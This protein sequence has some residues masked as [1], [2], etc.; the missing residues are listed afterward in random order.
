[1]VQVLK[2][3]SDAGPP[4]LI[5]IDDASVFE[6]GASSAALEGELEGRTEDALNKLR[7]IGD[8]IAEVCGSIQSAVAARMA[9]TKPDEFVLEF[10]VKISGEGSA[11]ISKVSGEASLKVTATWRATKA[12]PGA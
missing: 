5:E 7:E 2:A 11:I 12:A 4:V 3:S 8:S 10:G 6:V 1:M 9:K